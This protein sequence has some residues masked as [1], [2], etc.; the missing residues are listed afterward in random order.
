[1]TFT[2]PYDTR[3]FL[4]VE[5]GDSH[6]H[7]LS[8]AIRPF[9]QFTEEP[10][11]TPPRVK[12]K[13]LPTAR[14]IRSLSG[15]LCFEDIAPSEYNVVVQRDAEVVDRFFIKPPAGP[16]TDTLE[17]PIKLLPNVVLSFDLQLA[18]RPSY[19][20]P[21]HATLVRGFVTQ[22]SKPAA[23]AVVR[24]TYREVN[25]ADN[26]QTILVTVESLTNTD[27]EYVTFFK[28][29][30]KLKSADPPLTA[31]LV[32]VKGTSQS[33]TQTVEIKEGTTQ[34]ANDLPL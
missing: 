15:L 22:D 18:P 23:D 1:M 24:A 17:I 13:E 25:P 4:D 7:D 3:F 21:L 20:F 10:P 33:P 2:R 26:T 34:K 16:W 14:S 11:L 12:L 30:P 31:D 6:R 27:G 32:A 28:R 29:L 5:Q 19:P 8:I 9:D